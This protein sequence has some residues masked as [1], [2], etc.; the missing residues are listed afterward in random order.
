MYITNNIKYIGV[1]DHKIDLF[2]GQYIVPNGMAYNS[3]VILDEKVCIMDTVDQN[4]VTEWLDN[5]EKVLNGRTPDYLVIHHME[6]DHSSGIIEFLMKYPNAYVVGNLKTFKMISQ[7]FNYDFTNKVIVNDKDILKLGKHELTFT[8]APMV[9]WPEVMVSYDSYEKVLFSADVFGKFGALDIEE[10]WACEAR[11]Y[12]FGIVGMYGVQAQNLLKKVTTLD[13][14]IIC[15]LHGPVL[16]ENLDYY[17]NLYNIWTS[18][19]AESQGVLIAYTSI[20]GNTKKAVLLLKEQ[21]ENLGCEKVV[22]CDLARDEVSEAVEDAFRYPNIIL[23]TTTYNG[24]IFPFMNSFLETLIEHKIQN[25]RIG[26]I[27]NGSWANQVD[28]VIIKKLE[29]TK[30]N[31]IL[32]NKVSILSSVSDKN[33]DEI[34]LLAKELMKID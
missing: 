1:N 21:L 2:E 14:N 10:D 20:Y 24:S 8:F 31:T 17:I 29:G 27:G 22:L 13:I 3:Y 9:H 5:L 25:K 6:P 18:Y 30:N 7:F 34:K 12:Y 16:N 26:I 32:E 4:F 19:N 33:V 28:R 23:A 11:R 15:P